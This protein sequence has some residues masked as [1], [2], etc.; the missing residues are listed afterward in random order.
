MAYLFVGLSVLFLTVK[1][2]CSKRTSNMMQSGR[3]PFLFSL[4]RMMLCVLVGLAVVFFERSASLAITGRMAAIC[5]L[6]GASNAVMLAAWIVAVRRCTMVTLD[7]AGTLS[8]MLPAVLCAIF[9]GERIS[10]Y[11]M[12]GFSLIVLA[13]AVLSW[14]NKSNKKRPGML[15][16]LFVLLNALGDGLA[17]FSQQLYVHYFTAGGS[18]AGEVLYPKSVFHFYTYLFG[19]ITLFVFLLI[20]LLLERRAPQEKRVSAAEQKRVLRRAF[21]LIAIMALCLFLA[22]WF[23]TVATGDFGMSSQVLYPLI[24]GSCLVT[25]NLVAAAF[26]GEKMTRYSIIGSLLAIGGIV[27]MSLV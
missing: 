9:F 20:E 26:F 15:G 24:K 16:I 22:N 3:D 27:V 12:L 8:S 19:A 2:Y 11:K 10:G 21:P 7:V 25:A 13:T 6:S 18:R 4:L 14:H 23:Q 1:G 5:L 17:S